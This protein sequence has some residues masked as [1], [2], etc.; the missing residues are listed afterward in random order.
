MKI[1]QN[2]RRLLDRDWFTGWLFLSP[3]LLIWGSWTLVPY[4][5]SVAR[6]FQNVDLLRID[7]ATFAGLGNYLRVL[8]DPEFYHALKNSFLTAA[9]AVP[10][11]TVLALAAAVAVDVKLPGRSFFRTI[12]SIPYITSPIAVTTVFMVLFRRGNVLS[13]LFSVVLGLPNKTW[14]ADIHLALPFIMLVFVWRNIGF[15]MIIYL[16][17]LQDIPKELYEA[18]T[19]DGARGFKQVLFITV[20][21][22][23]NVTFFVT[24]LGM[25]NA[26]K[27]FDEVAAI[28]RYGALGSPAGTTST[29]VT[30]FYQVGIRYR[31]MGQG[32]ASV[33]IFIFLLVI[34]TL[35]QKRLMRMR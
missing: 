32:S 15:Y 26:F 16:A 9:I 22:L 4:V 17:G 28:S 33:V 12:F 25:I 6:S 8:T 20:P 23:R 27:I 19:V 21:M 34:F 2:Y 1:R 31:A 24:T 29:L 18:A 13:E 10:L 3:F 14:Y 35:I 30:Y 7:E 5:E 11:Q